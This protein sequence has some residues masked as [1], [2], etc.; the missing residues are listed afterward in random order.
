M[1]EQDCLHPPQEPDAPRP[2]RCADLHDACDDGDGDG[3]DH[4]DEDGVAEEARTQGG[5][6]GQTS[7]AQHGQLVVVA[8]DAAVET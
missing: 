3:D 4:D 2:P 7:E 1:Y 6:D 5:L 8:G